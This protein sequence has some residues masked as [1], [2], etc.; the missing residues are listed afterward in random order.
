MGHQEPELLD[1]VFPSFELR[2]ADVRL[3]LVS[4]P[5][6]CVALLCRHL[7]SRGARKHGVG[8]RMNSSLFAMGG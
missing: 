2:F 5:S 3:L 6:R 4:V 8:S 7:P 1:A